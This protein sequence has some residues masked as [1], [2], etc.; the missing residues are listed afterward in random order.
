[1]LFDVRFDDWSDGVR[2]ARIR[3]RMPQL[4]KILPHMR[5]RSNAG[6]SGTSWTMR[7]AS[8]GQASTQNPQK[9]QRE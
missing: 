6:K 5:W 8:S 3:G 4:E 1:V 7:I 9:M 2:F